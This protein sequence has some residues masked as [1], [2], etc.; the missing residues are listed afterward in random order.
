MPE[1]ISLRFFDRSG[2]ID[3]FQSVVGEGGGRIK[4]KFGN[5]AFPDTGAESHSVREERRLKREIQI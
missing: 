3:A 1:L 4:K 5:P 2:H